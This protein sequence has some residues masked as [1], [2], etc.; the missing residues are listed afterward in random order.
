MQY[1]THTYWPQNDY[2]SLT[3]NKFLAE[4][5]EKHVQ[6]KNLEFHYSFK[7]LKKMPIQIKFCN[8]VEYCVIAA[9]L[10]ILK[11]EGS[12]SAPNYGSSLLGSSINKTIRL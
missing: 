6:I 11:Q 12:Q 8:T 5:K 7:C 1:I 4:C 2:G 9:L 3:L 10:Q